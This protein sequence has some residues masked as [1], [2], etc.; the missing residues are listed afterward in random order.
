MAPLRHRLQV[1]DRL[2][3]LDL[4]HAV[5]S[6]PAGGTGQNQVRVA[7]AVCRANRHFFVVP[8]IDANV[9]PP[10]PSRLELS[11]DS[12]VLQLFPDG[13]QEDGRQL[14]LREL[15]SETTLGTIKRA[16]LARMRELP[17]PA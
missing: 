4:D 7:R 15:S 5:Q 8:D 16:I 2:R 1:V 11:N 10:T 12:V 17:Q 14:P 3:G 13:A 9:K 6:T